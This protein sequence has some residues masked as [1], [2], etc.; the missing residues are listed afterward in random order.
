MEVGMDCHCVARF[1]L[2]NLAVG[3]RPVSLGIPPQGRRRSGESGGWSCVCNGFCKFLGGHG[4]LGSAIYLRKRL[5]PII[6]TTGAAQL[7]RSGRPAGEYEGKTCGRPF[8]ALR[9]WWAG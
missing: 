6:P 5:F 1:E 8:S 3:L 2:V 7:R 4:G 9:K